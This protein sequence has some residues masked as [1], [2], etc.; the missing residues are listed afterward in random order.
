VLDLVAAGGQVPAA[1]IEKAHAVIDLHRRAVTRAIEA[2]VKIAMGTDSG[3]GPHGQN[4][5]EL[6]LMVQCGMTPAQALVATT[7]EAARL[8]GVDDDRGTIEPR[9]RADLV[10]LTGSLDDMTG[11]AGRVQHVWKDGQRVAGNL[12]QVTS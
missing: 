12:E 1:V 6:D 3:V 8:L 9:K 10:V 5:R 2:G 4:L 11:L 7:S